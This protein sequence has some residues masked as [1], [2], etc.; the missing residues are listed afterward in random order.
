MA[1][2]ERA[3]AV[4]KALPTGS[5]YEQQKMC[6]ERLADAKEKVGPRAARP[7]S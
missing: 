1:A 6:Y 3:L 4:M 5:P 7:G 2:A